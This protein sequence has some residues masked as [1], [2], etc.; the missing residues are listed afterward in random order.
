MMSK[1]II[2]FHIY[3]ILILAACNPVRDRSIKY[4]SKSEIVDLEVD[5][6][7]DYYT[8]DSEGVVVKYRDKKK[9]FTYSNYNLGALATIDVTNPHKILLFYKEQQVIVLL[10]NT[11]TEIGEILLDN[12][13]FFS[14]IGLSNDGNIW[15]YDSFLSKLK[16]IGNSGK[17]IEES[18]P[19]SQI[20]PENIVDSKIIDRGN[21]VIIADENKGVLLFNNMG[22]F[23]KL[24][25]IKNITKPTIVKNTL[26]YFNQKQNCYISNKLDVFSKE[27]KLCFNKYKLYPKII[28]FENSKFYMLVNNQVEIFTGDSF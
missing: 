23:D 1:T 3:F 18:F 19:V 5:K 13:S 4:H 14:A 17:E 2:I 20:N 8:R 15:V 28:V 6:L 26:Y 9:I 27:E 24:L 25:Q 21:Y 7:G 11:L 22:F 16:K 10:D 12:N